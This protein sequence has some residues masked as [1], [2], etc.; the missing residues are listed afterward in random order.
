MSATPRL[1]AIAVNALRYA[2]PPGRCGRRWWDSSHGEAGQGYRL[3]CRVPEMADDTPALG[4]D[5]RQRAAAPEPG[6]RGTMTAG[7]RLGS[8][9]QVG[10]ADKRFRLSVGT[11]TVAFG[12]G[13]IGTVPP[14]GA[15]SPRWST[16][17]VE[18]VSNLPAA[19]LTVPLTPAPAGVS[20]QQP[21]PALG[22]APGEPRASPRTALDLIAGARD[23]H[24][25]GLREPGAGDS[26]SPYGPSH[27]A[28]GAS[29]RLPL[30]DCGRLRH[31][32]GAGGLRAAAGSGPGVPRGR[33]PATSSR[34][35]R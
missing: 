7:P 29:P 33:R 32:G 18:A 11:A 24:R 5:R 22:G 28:A 21:F 34:G 1:A 15:S 6:R 9:D 20:L 8:G 3:S 16:R 12:D 14:A 17:S 10:P 31:P 2:T 4:P 26:R 23:G 35:A 27:R 13:R 19:R 30:L 25:G